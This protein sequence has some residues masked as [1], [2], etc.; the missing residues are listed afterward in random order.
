MAR[1]YGDFIHVADLA[2]AHVLAAHR[3]GAGSETAA[4]NLGTG[5]GYSVKQ[6]VAAAERVTAAESGPSIATAAGESA[7]SCIRPWIRPQSKLGWRPAAS[8]LVKADRG[9]LRWHKTRSR[10]GEDTP[11]VEQINE[12]RRIHEL[13]P[14]AIRKARP[15][16]QP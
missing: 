3:L 8:M 7:G 13:E 14:T 10:S 1:A 16:K 4:Y 5:E 11:S 15:R 12:E 9:R 2:D 6:V